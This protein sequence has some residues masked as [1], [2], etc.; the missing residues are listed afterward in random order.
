MLMAKKRFA[1][2]CVIFL[3]ILFTLV[4][5]SN[6][7]ITITAEDAS[8]YGIVETNMSIEEKL[9]DFEYMYTLLEENYPFFEVNKRL[10]NVD[11]LKNKKKYENIIKNTK[12]DAE[13]FLAIDC[14]LS[15]LNNPH[16]HVFN[17]EV[18]KR[19]YKHFHPYEHEVLNY[20]KSME[21][22]DFDGNV[23]KIK[24]NPNSDFLTSHDEVLE[25]KVLIEDE[26]AYMKIS[27]MSYNHIKEDY[28]KV[29]AFLKE[30]EDYDKLIIDIRGNTG[31][32]DDYWKNIVGFLIDDTLKVEYYSFYRGAYRDKYDLYAVP[33][34]KPLAELDGKNLDKFPAEVK[35]DFD[36]YTK[37]IVMV[38]PWNVLDFKGKVY[39]LVDRYVFSSAEKFASF[40]KDSGFATLIG[41]P[42]G[43]DRVFSEIPFA[44]LPNS[45]L[46]IRFSAELGINV[47]GTINMETKT[48]PHIEVDA[49]PNEDFNKDK[50]IQAA[51]ED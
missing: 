33:F 27:S 15:D 42:T 43:G 37:N 11:W 49:T 8:V 40:A 22:Y 44:Y 7:E 25:T 26:V 50:C 39:L 48:I 36:Y 19:F 12:N 17:G 46:I 6:E 30:V 3:T 24:L 35:E 2:K 41:E 5:C 1:S 51:L 47:D 13:F 16:T 38:Q 18:Y 31:G 45:G 20:E 32:F 14:I 21:R 34:S 28:K 10:H 23:E 4:A 29:E 9:E